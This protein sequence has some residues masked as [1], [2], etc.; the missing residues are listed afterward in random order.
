[1]LYMGSWALGE[2]Q[3]PDAEHRSAPTTSAS[4]RFPA[5][6]R[7]RREHRPD[8]GER[9]HPGRCSPAR[10][11]ATN[12]AAWLK[13]IAA[14]YGAAVAQGQRRRSPASSRPA[15]G[16]P[17][18]AHARA[19]RT[20]SPRPRR[21]CCGSRRCSAPRPPRQPEQRRAAGQRLHQPAQQFMQLV[22]AANAA[23]TSSTP[24]AADGGGHR[25]ATGAA[26][27]PHSPAMRRR[28]RRP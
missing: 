26:T 12:I 25:A 20:P 2:L 10:T 19:C 11:T 23:R 1:M 16:E 3:R 5:V 15:A 9:R 21:A 18:A 14:N 17:A 28:S 27:P 24:V 4:C 7:R 8:A 22:Q 13:C 6:D